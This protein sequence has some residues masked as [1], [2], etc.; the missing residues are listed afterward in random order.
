MAMFGYS[1]NPPPPI[2]PRTFT[3][4]GFGTLRPNENQIEKIAQ[5]R[6]NLRFFL[7]LLRKPMF[8][9]V[10]KLLGKSLMVLKIATSS[11][12]QKI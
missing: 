12:L 3:T 8:Q 4:E 7:Q 5:C 2:M 6:K 9:R 11:L 10:R 1:L